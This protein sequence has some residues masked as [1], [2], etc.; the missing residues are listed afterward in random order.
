MD[1]TACR[2]CGTQFESKSKKKMFCSVKCGK[3]HRVS[4]LPSAAVTCVYCGSSFVTVGSAA[5]CSFQC[6]NAARTHEPVEKI[7]VICSR[8]FMVEYK[9]RGVG[10]TCS[11]A[12]TRAKAVASTDWAAMGAITAERNR[13]RKHAPVD[14]RCEVCSSTFSVEFCDRSRRTCSDDCWVTLSRSKID[15]ADVGRKISVTRRE[16]IASGRISIV[17]HPHS[18]ETK[19]YLSGLFSDGRRKGTSNSMFGRKHA[20]GSRQRMSETRTRKI[21]NGEYDRSKWARRGQVFAVKANRTIPYRSSWELRA[22]ERL[23]ADH[24]VVSFLFEPVRLEYYYGF[25]QDGN[26]QLRH[27]VPDFIATHADGRRT[28]IE[29]KPANLINAAMNVAKAEAAREYCQANDMT[30]AFWTKSDLFPE[31]PKPI[32]PPLDGNT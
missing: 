26:E 3:Q 25:R 24:D 9:K 21:I 29:V 30:Y 18:D 31:V 5:F 10:V 2:H 4:L 16:G 11:V 32:G 7:C 28:M 17:G 15:Y 23:E 20:D 8:S 14:R 12:C 19:E 6:R 22:I 27:Y 13:A 1:K